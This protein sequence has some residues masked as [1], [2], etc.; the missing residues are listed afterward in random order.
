MMFFWASRLRGRATPCLRVAAWV[1][2]GGLVVCWAFLLKQKKLNPKFLLSLPK[3]VPP[4]QITSG[5]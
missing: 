1:K 4:A 2:Q 5:K 3:G